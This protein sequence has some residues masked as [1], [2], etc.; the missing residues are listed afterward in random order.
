MHL[1]EKVDGSETDLEITRDMYLD[2]NQPSNIEEENVVCGPPAYPKIED[3]NQRFWNRYS[4]AAEAIETIIIEYGMLCIR[5]SRYSLN[6]SGTRRSSIVTVYLSYVVKS[7]QNIADSTVTLIYKL[8]WRWSYSGGSAVITKDEN[9]IAEYGAKEEKFE[10][11]LVQT[12]AGAQ[13]IATKLMANYSIPRRD[14]SITWRG[15]PRL[16]LGDVVEVP[17][18]KTSTAKFVVVKHRWSFDGGLEC[19]TDARK[20]AEE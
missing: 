18:Y 20:V 4:I 17:E 1:P 2:K 6:E 3:E 13:L 7:L 14:L 15:D 8:A 12:T 16:E 11:H 9:L 5:I 19:V 10:N